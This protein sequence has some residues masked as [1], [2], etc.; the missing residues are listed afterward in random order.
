MTI[1]NILWL[2]F[3]FCAPARS[4]AALSGCL[5]PAAHCQDRA[6]A[7]LPCHHVGAVLARLEVAVSALTTVEGRRIGRHQK[8]GSMVLRSS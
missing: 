6:P 8:C 7:E 5:T 1:G 4:E 2:F 3:L